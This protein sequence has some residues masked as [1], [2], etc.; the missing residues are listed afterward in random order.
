[1][2]L[3]PFVATA[4][5]PNA[6]PA[7]GLRWKRWVVGGLLLLLVVLGGALL[8]LDP[9]LRHS[10]E[11]QVAKRSNGRYNLKIS[12]LHVSIWQQSVYVRGV[13]LRTKAVISDTSD[14]PPVRL[15]LGHARLVGVGLWSLVRRGV[16]P[17]DSLVLDS[18]RARL[19]AAPSLPKTQ[20]PLYQRLPLQL[21][22]LRLGYLGVGHLQ[23]TYRPTAQ[24]SVAL[25]QAALAVHDILISAAGAA[26]SQRIGYAAAVAFQ[27][28]GVA[29]AGAGHTLALGA[30]RFASEKKQLLVDSLVVHPQQAL[31]NTRSRNVRVQ[32]SLPQL[33]L[34]GLQTARLAHREFYADSLQL[35]ALHLAATAPGVPPPPLHVLVE[36]FMHRVYLGKLVATHGAGRVLGVE[37]APQVQNVNLRATALRVD[38]VGAADVHRVFYAQQWD[39]RTGPASMKIDAP[40]YQLEYGQAHVATNQGL[41]LLRNVRFQPTMSAAELSR[42]KH[43]QAPHVTA[44]L[45]ELRANGLDFAALAHHGNLRIQT[46]IVEQARLQTRSDGRYPINPEESVATPDAVQKL[47]RTIDVRRI[48]MRNGTLY[49]VYRAPKNPKPGQLTINRISGTI[50]NFSNDPQHMSAA[51]PATIHA[52]A[53]LQNQCKLDATFRGNLLD[54]QG[55]HTINGTFGAGQLPILNSMTQ[56]TEQLGFRSGQINHIRFQMQF[57]RQQAR[58]TMWAAYSNLKLNVLS[59][60]GGED[61]KTLGSRIKTTLVNGIFIR[62]DNPRKGKLQ[63]G[64][65]ISDRDLRVSAFALWRQGIVSGMLNSA[66]VPGKLA[67]KV[68]E[69]QDTPTYK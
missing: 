1:M 66:G 54:P 7:A 26:D 19:L 56:P 42:R 68:S 69:K 51:H 49:S 31:S 44:F 33:V 43:H 52:I 32:F 61:H 63:P 45:T 12:D 18:L 11:K 65:I 20:K 6:P 39:V 15:D 8:A 58:G 36:K 64:Q 17:I 13:H 24:D 50:T 30:L 40:F 28:R 46:L 59:L 9:W 60:K 41:A 35:T 62:D 10:L 16:V 37:L 48:S 25:R 22:G 14:L 2:P 29:A 5:P 23:A 67:K 57:D 21:D 27:V 53:W 38:S 34:S 4:T 3:P 55:R 47:D